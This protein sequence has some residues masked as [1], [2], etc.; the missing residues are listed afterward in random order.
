MFS[1]RHTRVH[2]ARRIQVGAPTA[3]RGVSVRSAGLPSATAV[4]LIGIGFDDAQSAT[5]QGEPRAGHRRSSV[6]F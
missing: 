2:R 1:D 5:A 4:P 6:F 3:P